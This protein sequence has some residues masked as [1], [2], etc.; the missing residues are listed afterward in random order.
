[1]NSIVHVEQINETRSAKTISPNFLMINKPIIKSSGKKE[2]SYK[3]LIVWFDIKNIND[4][5]F[6]AKDLPAQI[7]LSDVEWQLMITKNGVL[8]ELTPNNEKQDI[9]KW[10]SYVIQRDAKAQVIS[11]ENCIIY[12]LEDTNEEISFSYNLKFKSDQKLGITNMDNFGENKGVINFE[13]MN[14]NHD[15]VN[16]FIYNE[17]SDEKFT[18]VSRSKLEVINKV[19]LK[20]LDNVNNPILA[21]RAVN[22]EKKTTEITK[23]DQ[24]KAELGVISQNGISYLHS[25]DKTLKIAQKGNVFNVYKIKGNHYDF[26]TNKWVESDEDKTRFIDDKKL[27][28]NFKFNNHNYDFETRVEKLEKE[29][30]HKKFND[31]VTKYISYENLKPNTK[32]DT[33]VKA[34]KSWK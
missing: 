15:F 11:K 26:Q 3:R 19:P 23:S 10:K 20:P 9:V 4:R 8:K 33:F 29:I 27:K 24:L 18:V 32:F 5:T 17:N 34:G 31:Q 28:I 6:D 7:K 16:A 13:P 12:D 14:N 30:G 1:M 21:V 2:T 22:E 25:D